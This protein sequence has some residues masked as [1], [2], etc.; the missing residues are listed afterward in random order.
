VEVVPRY[1]K[2]YTEE[3]T[4]LSNGTE[5]FVDPISCVTKTAGLPVHGNDI[6]PPRYKVGGKWFCSYPELREC[7]DPAILPVDEVRIEGLKMNDIGLGKSIYTKKKLDEHAAF[8]DS[9]ELGE[10]IW[11]R[12]MSWH[13]L[14]RME[15]GE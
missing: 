9:Q 12:L 14:S 5:V 15:R 7:H 8:Q 13:I 6:A 2:N 10:R 3:I 11:L 1:H 4:A